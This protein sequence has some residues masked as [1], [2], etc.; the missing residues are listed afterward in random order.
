MLPAPQKLITASCDNKYKNLNTFNHLT[1]TA[2]KPPPLLSP[3][4]SSHC[5]IGRKRERNIAKK[6]E[7]R[8]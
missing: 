5:C 1:S 3:S 8:N 4:L 7:N 2:A 6:E